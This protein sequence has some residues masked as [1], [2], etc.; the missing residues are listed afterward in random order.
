VALECCSA[1]KPRFSAAGSAV[2]LPPQQV[3]KQ[4]LRYSHTFGLQK[5]IKIPSYPEYN[6]DEKNNFKATF[7]VNESFQSY[8]ILI[9]AK[10]EDTGWRYIEIPKSEINKNNQELHIPDLMSL[11]KVN[12]RSD[13][14]QLWKSREEAKQIYEKEYK[15]SLEYGSEQL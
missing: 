14:K 13:E 1:T 12:S 11:P 2:Q 4:L 5:H 7:P 15:K 6:L 3:L 10:S 9:K 8:L